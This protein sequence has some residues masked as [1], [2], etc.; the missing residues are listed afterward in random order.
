M[1]TTGKTRTCASVSAAVVALISTT[2]IDRLN[3]TEAEEPDDMVEVEIA[4]VHPR[5]T[6]RQAGKLWSRTGKVQPGVIVH[7]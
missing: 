6:G 1:I 4:T 7:E 2:E 3:A 5:Q